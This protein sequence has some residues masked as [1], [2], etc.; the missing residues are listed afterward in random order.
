MVSRLFFLSCFG[1]NAL[2]PKNSIVTENIKLENWVLKVERTLLEVSLKEEE[3]KINDKSWL[4]YMHGSEC[5]K[6]DNKY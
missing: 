3:R 6:I 2:I 4:S 5:N 1:R